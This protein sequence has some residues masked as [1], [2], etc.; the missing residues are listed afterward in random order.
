MPMPPA[1]AAPNTAPP[2]TGQPV[3]HMAWA[4]VTE[5]LGSEKGSKNTN[6][7]LK[8]VIPSSLMRRSVAV[9]N[10]PLTS[11]SPS[12]PVSKLT[13][14]VIWCVPI[15]ITGVTVPSPDMPSASKTC[16]GKLPPT[17]SL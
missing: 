14:A 2:K 5:F 3:T 9:G 17:S 15:S 13:S 6:P 4:V 10:V 1:P 8:S 7:L 16:T 11:N 12:L